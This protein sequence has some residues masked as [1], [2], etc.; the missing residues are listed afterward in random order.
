MG[1]E[2]LDQGR[3]MVDGFDVRRDRAKALSRV[4]YVPQTN[5]LYRDL[6]IADHMHFAAAQ[7]PNFDRGY[8]FDRVHKVGLASHRRVGELSGGEQ[9]QVALALALGTR[10]HVLLLDEPLAGLDPLARREFLAALADDQRASG[11]TVLLSSQIITDVDEA[12]DAIVVLT[13]GHVALHMSVAQ[14][15]IGHI[16]VPES[17]L[18]ERVAVA[19]FIGPHGGRLALLK[20]EAAGGREATLEE[21][22]L[23]YLASG[24][25]ENSARSSPK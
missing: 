6:T 16:A 14:A 17:E 12:C 8:A 3:V 5:S 2:R 4:G 20:S 7:R 21:V 9:A 1:F 24:R 19:T 10:A 23:G 22:V 15:R 11:A 13:S 25:S 18:G